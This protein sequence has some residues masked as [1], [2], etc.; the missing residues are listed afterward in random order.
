MVRCDDGLCDCFMF[1]AGLQVDLPL[2]HF[3]CFGL[4]EI[5]YTSRVNDERSV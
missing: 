1:G 2:F 3:C 4:E 5:G